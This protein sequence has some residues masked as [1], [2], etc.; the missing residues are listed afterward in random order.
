MIQLTQ[1]MIDGLLLGSLYAL[2]AVGLSICLG[3]IRVV[4]FAH[5]D[6]IMLGAYGAFWM[7]ALFGLDPLIALPI[8]GCLGFAAG[9]GLFK[10]AYEPL[11]E[12]PALNQILLTFGIG[13][14]L[15]N[16]AVILWTGDVRSAMPSY[17]TAS[18]ALGDLVIPVGQLIAFGVVCALVVLLFLWLTRTELGRASRALAEN[19]DAAKLMGINVRF[20]YALTF[21][22]SAALAGVSGTIMSFIVTVTPF[23]GFAMMIKSFSIIILG[24]FGSIVGAIVGAFVLGM[25]ETLVANYVPDGAGWSEGVA[26]ALIFLILIVRPSGI[27]GQSVQSEP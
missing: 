24:G 26:F 15:Q 21:G 18:I 2:M 12:S 11:L 5:G 17:A 16:L 10:L 27:V 14:V 20:V 8:I 7:L 25:A 9:Y 22:I 13:L 23:M 4:N 1:A 3:I 19:R 6:F